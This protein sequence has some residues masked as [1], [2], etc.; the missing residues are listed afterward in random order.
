VSAGPEERISD[1]LKL[2][3]QADVRYLGRVLGFEPHLQK[4]S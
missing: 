3:L 4:R 2:E 1:P